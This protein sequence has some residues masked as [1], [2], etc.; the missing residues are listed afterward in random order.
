MTLWLGTMFSTLLVVTYNS[1]TLSAAFV[2]VSSTFLT[3]V[4]YQV[5]PSNWY[6]DKSNF[7]CLTQELR[8]RRQSWDDLRTS[9]FLSP[10]TNSESMH[11]RVGKGNVFCLSCTESENNCG[12]LAKPRAQGQR[13]FCVLCNWLV[14][15]FAEEKAPRQH[16]L[17]HFCMQRRDLTFSFGTDWYC[18]PDPV[19]PAWILVLLAL[20]LAQD[21][22]HYRPQLLERG[23]SPRQHGVQG[24]DGIRIYLL[25]VSRHELPEWVSGFCPEDMSVV[26]CQC[27]R[28]STLDVP[29]SCELHV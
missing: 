9:P 17:S 22:R 6:C 20:L 11:G 7:P 3:S 1:Q 18:E 26:S 4:S 5:I 13:P 12:G 8:P 19:W 25:G 29:E 21:P 15:G 10:K 28:E 23:N 14:A 2:K 24:S 16:C 27:N